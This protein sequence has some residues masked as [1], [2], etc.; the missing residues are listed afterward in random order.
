MSKAPP[1]H[2][3]IK[4]EAARRGLIA[5]QPERQAPTNAPPAA[6]KPTD[7]TTRTLLTP[8]KG[9]YQPPQPLAAAAG[10]KALAPA[11]YHD[12]Q[13]VYGHFASGGWGVQAKVGDRQARGW[14]TS[15]PDQALKAQCRGRWRGRAVVGDNGRLLEC[16]WSPQTFR[17]GRH[18]GVSISYWPLRQHEYFSQFL[19]TGD[20]E[21]YGMVATSAAG[22]MATGLW[23]RG[24]PQHNLNDP[25]V[26]WIEVESHP[27]LGVWIKA[28]GH[29]PRA[30]L[31]WTEPE[32]EPHWHPEPE[33][34]V[35][36]PP[37][38]AS[39]LLIPNPEFHVPASVAE[40]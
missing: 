35:E 37:S 15:E 40:V 39:Y 34:V 4:Q 11:V 33:P 19:P 18:E 8:A 27:R 21:I 3:Q 5:R 6:T 16:D 36:E 29:R 1:T 9:H 30:P 32:R 28:C 7:Q 17:V 13:L 14:V 2:E 24:L 22:F 23:W 10:F 20:A 12:A 38:A 31:P 25:W 26:G